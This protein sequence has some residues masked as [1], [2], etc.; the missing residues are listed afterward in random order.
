MFQKLKILWFQML[1]KKLYQ[2]LYQ[3]RAKVCT[4]THHKNNKEDTPHNQPTTREVTKKDTLHNQLTT[5]E[6]TKKDT[7]HNQPTTKEVTKDNNML[8]NQPTTREVTKNNNTVH[9][10][11]ITREVTKGD[12]LHNQL[13][14]REVT[15]QTTED[16]T[17]K[18]KMFVR[19]SLNEW[20]KNTEIIFLFFIFAL[21]NEPNK[22]F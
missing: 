5:R 19:S 18:N 8:H 16:T 9:N 14:T 21:K 20:G 15:N 13:I 3:T 10:Q 6:V 2:R 7:L 22:L 11:P 4:I 1:P 12:T 17:N